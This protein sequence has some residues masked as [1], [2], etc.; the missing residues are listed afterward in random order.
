[1]LRNASDLKNFRLGARDGEIGRVKDLYFDDRHWMVRYLVADTGNWLAHRLVLISP[2]SVLHAGSPSEKSIEV[3][4]TREQIEKSPLAETDK[5]VSRQFEIEY[6][7]YYNWPYYWE[8]PVVWAPRPAEIGGEPMAK[9]V[10]EAHGD[11]HLRSFQDVTGHAIHARDGSIGH[12]DDFLL[13][14]SSWMFRYLVVDTRNWWPAKKVLVSP[15]WVKSVDWLGSQ[16]DVD[17]SR[18][19]IKRAPEYVSTQPLTR[20]FES[21]LF[22]HYGREPYWEHR[23]A[24]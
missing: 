23:L 3:D 13:D 11:P 15:E 20:D 21:R 24:A 16:I 19:A 5:P 1:M 6:Y 10:P 22:A 2:N 7:N 4:L 14:D 18:E 8:G 9:E 17:L 12:V